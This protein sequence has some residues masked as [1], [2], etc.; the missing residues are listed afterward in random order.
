MYTITL[1][2]VYTL[3]NQGINMEVPK[4]L[5]EMSEQ[6]N[7][8]DN[9]CT[10][11]PVWQVRC[12][13]T[14]ATSSEY[15]D[16][17]EFIETDDHTVVAKSNDEDDVNQQIIDYLDCDFDDLPVVIESWVDDRTDLGEYG[18]RRGKG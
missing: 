10:A 8:E 2:I 1:Y 3:I 16:I 6:M 9:R 7:N 14:R 15:T 12:K 17:F 11:D 4:F 18:Q 5:L 13:R